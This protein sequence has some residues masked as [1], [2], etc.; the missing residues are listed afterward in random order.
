M[1]AQLLHT[2]LLLKKI[3]RKNN[4]EIDYVDIKNFRQY[5]DVK[6][7]FS[8]ES[9]AKFTIIQ[10]PN[11]A[12]KTNLMNALTWCLF[13]K[14]LHVDSK[15]PG[16][17]MVNTTSLDEADRNP[18]VTNVEIQFIKPDGK[19]I[20]I[21]RQEHFKKSLSGKLMP[22]PT[23]NPFTI[24][25]EGERDW[26]GPIE[27]DDAKDIVNR[28]I[29]ESIEEYFFFDGERMDKYF[30]RT[31]G[32]QIKN[33]VFQMSQIDLLERVIKHLTSMRNGFIR[34]AKGLSS[35]AKE[36][37]EILEILNRSV[38]TDNEQLEEFK[39]KQAEANKQELFFSEKLKNSSL[40]KVASLED[41]R[42]ELDNDLIRIKEEIEEYIKK[43][44]KLLHLNMSSIFCYDALKET[45]ELI[46]NNKEAGLIPPHIRSIFIEGLLKKAKCICKSDISEKDEFCLKRRN[47][48]KRLLEK[49]MLSELSNEIVDTNVHITK[50][51][52]G[53]TDFSIEISDVGKKLR[54][55]EEIKEEKN[56]K[57]QRITEEIGT[58]NVE[59]IKNWENKKQHFGKERQQFQVMIALKE[60]D[61]E[62][63]KNIIRAR[64]KELRRELKR[65]D[66]HK[67]LANKL[68][69]CEQAIQ[70]ATNIKEKIMKEMKNEIEKK[71][72]QQ[73]LK[74]I[75]K[76]KTYAGVKIDDNY[77]VSVPDMSGRE[78]I[79][80]L[81]A[82]ERQV[83]ALSFMAALNSVSGFRVP[84]IIDTLLAR[85]SREPRRS[86]AENLP[87]Y[88]E[89]NQVIL[90]V[91]EEEY[92]SE[93]E[94]ALSKSVGK[95]YEINFIEKELGGLAKVVCVK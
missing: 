2:C 81:S 56:K 59:N 25:I 45:K 30:T 18:V 70:A 9:N 87:K 67:Q 90:L 1:I 41:Q 51:L 55:L 31:T 16:L 95:K 36:I 66:K 65:E 78:A 26:I 73:F 77:M 13:G 32:T 61:N 84:V 15:Y 89:N 4:L 37:S 49:T 44:I 79:G 52:N 22:F 62:R 8:R 43:R 50:M 94:E 54:N 42:V 3:W 23:P 34:S 27:S 35:K 76:K 80:T 85:I 39:I 29:P 92:T 68:A 86:I 6:I 71:T 72:S 83:C 20:V 19:K 74:L 38:E 53:L 5:K 60:R 46:E 63:R 82:G 14:E 17:P 48:V 57:I 33:A 75:W 28:Y 7:F 88:L 91:T 58:I 93:V 69:F 12:G 47:N 24:M 10:G 21:R 11:G 40:A 64:E